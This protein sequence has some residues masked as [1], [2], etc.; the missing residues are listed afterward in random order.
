MFALSY[1]YMYGVGSLI[2]LGGTVLCLRVGALDLQNPRER[3]AFGIATAGL[4]VY[5]G[6]HALFQF[7][8]PFAG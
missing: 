7:V 5:A 2:Y 6:V 4:L 8:L 3:L 1:W